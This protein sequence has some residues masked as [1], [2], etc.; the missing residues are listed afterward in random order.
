MATPPGFDPNVLVSNAQASP[1]DQA[2]E[3]QA[4]KKSSPHHQ[5]VKSADHFDGPNRQRDFTNKMVLEKRSP[6]E[7]RVLSHL[8]SQEMP[9]KPQALPEHY[10]QVVKDPLLQD[11]NHQN[12]SQGLQNRSMGN[13]AALSKETFSQLFR[14][15]HFFQDK[16]TTVLV[17]K[18]E[19]ALSREAKTEEGGR[20]T[21][22][23]ES[24][25]EGLNQQT[26]NLLQKVEASINKNSLEGLLKRLF[27]GEEMIPINTTTCLGLAAKTPESWKTFFLNILSKGSVEQVVSQK[28]Q[29]LVDALF[30][31]LYKATQSG[32][33]LVTDLRF[34][35][36]EKVLSEKF[37]RVLVENPEVLLALEKLQP[38]ET[39]AP[40]ILTK[41]GEELQFLK[42]AHVPAEAATGSALS[43]VKSQANKEAREKLEQN[44]VHERKKRLLAGFSGEDAGPFDQ[45]YGTPLG[46]G[47]FIDKDQKLKRRSFIQFV[48]TLLGLT[49]AG[50]LIFLLFQNL[51]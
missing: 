14:L 30:R 3:L 19:V 44:L 45:K 35:N 27:A 37:A 18:E 11:P 33:T 46:A 25:P 23:S 43:L 34:Q 20:L 17:L 6:S 7:A 5:E 13:Q 38:G 28:L 48:L 4:K 51:R 10:R 8:A 9:R 2:E 16:P 39:L 26:L 21:R 41:L 50:L 15:R 22:G 12:L 42:L 32:M 47:G 36:G 49:L 29:S 40:D 1:A 24:L 31:G